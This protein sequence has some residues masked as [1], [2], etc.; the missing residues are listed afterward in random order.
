MKIPDELENW[1]DTHKIS[2]YDLLCIAF[3]PRRTYMDVV[4]G[5][6]SVA[7]RQRLFLVTNLS[8]FQLT[9]VEMER[10]GEIKERKRAIKLDEKIA[11]Y[12]LNIW[13]ENQKVPIGEER[14]VSGEKK[15]Q[16]K[17]VLTSRLVKFID[18]QKD[19]TQVVSQVSNNL[20]YLQNEIEGLM[21]LTPGAI[22]DY[23]KVNAESLRGVYGLIHIILFEENPREAFKTLIKSKKIL[24]S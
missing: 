14:L 13:K 5:I 3:V 21:D 16:D 9:L 20:Q 4:N 15:S 23:T 2:I 17:I 7:A 8:M 6:R 19:T 18:S 10:Y 24:T 11:L 1:L 22:K 12:F